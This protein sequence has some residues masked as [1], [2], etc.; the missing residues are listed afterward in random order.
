MFEMPCFVYVC[1][2]VGG[3]NCVCVTRETWQLSVSYTKIVQFTTSRRCLI[4]S[5]AVGAFFALPNDIVIPITSAL[6]NAK[7]IME[8]R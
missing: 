1:V 8:A 7:V 5:D 6:H 4:F 2:D 3:L